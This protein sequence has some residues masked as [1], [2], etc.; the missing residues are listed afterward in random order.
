MLET[1]AKTRHRRDRRKQRGQS[2]NE[3]PPFSGAT[4]CPRR[5]ATTC[6][7]TRKTACVHCVHK[8]KCTLNKARLKAC[9]RWVVSEG[10]TLTSSL[11]CVERREQRSSPRA[12][13]QQQPC[14]PQWGP[15][16]QVVQVG[17]GNSRFL[18]DFTQNTSQQ[19]FQ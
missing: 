7:S 2:Q 13:R 16:V 8:R 4:S 3:C 9:K 10:M 14:W 6:T 19:S 15:Q 5:R 11:G 18:S 1:N 17:F 12:H